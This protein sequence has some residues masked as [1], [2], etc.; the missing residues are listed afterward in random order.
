LCKLLRG[1]CRQAIRHIFVYIGV[2]LSRKRPTA[3]CPLLDAIINNQKAL[4]DELMDTK[5]VVYFLAKSQP[6]SDADTP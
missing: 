6:L 5:N 1:I 3:H 4:V 2:L